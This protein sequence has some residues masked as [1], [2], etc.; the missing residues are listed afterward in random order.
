MFQVSPPQRYFLLVLPRQ[1][2]FFTIPI[3]INLWLVRQE[4]L[5]PLQ[6]FNIKLF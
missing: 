3:Q 6:R 5:G 1:V 4:V 2:R